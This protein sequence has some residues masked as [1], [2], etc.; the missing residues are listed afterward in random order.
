MI[1]RLVV[2]PCFDLCRSNIF[3]VQLNSIAPMQQIADFILHNT[4]SLVQYSTYIEH[5]F[6]TLYG[7]HQKECNKFV[8][9]EYQNAANIYVWLLNLCGK[10]GIRYSSVFL[11]KCT[12]N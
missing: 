6:V 2:L 10:R 12:T 5:W 7:T 4:V 3:Q 9:C 11:A 1:F 8:K